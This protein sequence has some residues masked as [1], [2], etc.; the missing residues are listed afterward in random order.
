MG[1]LFANGGVISIHTGM[2]NIFNNHSLH[3]NG[4]RCNKGQKMNERIKQLAIQADIKFLEFHGKEYCEAWVEQQE[5]FA[6]LIIQECGEI[7][8]YTLKE[9]T[10]K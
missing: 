3:K 2:G 10:R 8:F 7:A 9:L 4:G 1:V 5:K 6:E